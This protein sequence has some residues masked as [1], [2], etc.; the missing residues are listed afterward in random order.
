MYNRYHISLC[1]YHGTLRSFSTCVCVFLVWLFYFFNS[2]RA[3]LH[4]RCIRIFQCVWFLMPCW[5]PTNKCVFSQTD[6]RVEGDTF[7]VTHT[8]DCF[9][10]RPSGRKSFSV[11]SFFIIFFPD[12]GNFFDVIPV[13]ISGFLTAWVKV[14][15]FSFS[16]S[17]CK[18]RH[19]CTPS[20]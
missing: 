18:K 16:L 17:S 2:A 14:C 11:K 1:C 19:S 4:L 15:V 5:K 10:I 7:H 8:R 12:V 9:Y 13:C 6:T 3:T 20:E